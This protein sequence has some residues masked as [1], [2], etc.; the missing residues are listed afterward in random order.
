MTAEVKEGYQRRYFNDSTGRISAALDA[1]WDFVYKDGIERTGDISGVQE[2]GDIGSRVSKP[3]GGGVVTYL[4]EIPLDLYRAD[5]LAKQSRVDATETD[6]L[7]DQAT[8]TE[9]S[10]NFYTNH[11]DGSPLQM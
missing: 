9:Q 3:A 6:M 2:G 7:P 1:G 10:K 11:Q 4:M 5:Q 8:D